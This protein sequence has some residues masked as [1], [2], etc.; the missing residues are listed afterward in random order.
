[1]DLRFEMY[2]RYRCFG[3]VLVFTKIRI[4]LIVEFNHILLILVLR[5]FSKQNLH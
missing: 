2:Y 3:C 4:Y 1:M 5:Y